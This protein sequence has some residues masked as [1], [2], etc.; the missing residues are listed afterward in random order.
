MHNLEYLVNSLTDKRLNFNVKMMK[1]NFL[2]LNNHP[3]KLKKFSSYLKYIEIVDVR[4][5]VLNIFGLLSC[6]SV[7]F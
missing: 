7:R 5:K 2:I 4:K 3:V 1:L 6:E